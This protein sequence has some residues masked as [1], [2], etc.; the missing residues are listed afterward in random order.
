MAL[1]AAGELGDP[2]LYHSLEKIAAREIQDPLIVNLLDAALE[3]C[4][5]E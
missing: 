4:A 5:P 2:K 1:E 3:S